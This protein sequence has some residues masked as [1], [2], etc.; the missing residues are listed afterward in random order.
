ML[1]DSG[2]PCSY[3]TGEFHLS[4]KFEIENDVWARIIPKKKFHFIRKKSLIPTIKKIHQIF[5]IKFP[6]H[7]H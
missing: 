6:I 3:E 7:S 5:F 4:G 2:L 1:I